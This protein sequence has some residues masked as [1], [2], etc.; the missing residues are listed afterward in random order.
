MYRSCVEPL[1]SRSPI[2]NAEVNPNVAAE[3]SPQTPTSYAV[4]AFSETAETL[5][6]T[7]LLPNKLAAAYPGQAVQVKVT[8]G[9]GA[10]HN[11]SLDGYIIRA[12]SAPQ[13]TIALNG[14]EDLADE[15]PTVGTAGYYVKKGV[16]QDVDA[17]GTE[18]AMV[19]ATVTLV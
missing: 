9:A 1:R 15:K 16:L 14:V 4:T 13:Y 11:E 2:E 7:V 5:V 8:G 10:L 3:T 6:A 12:G 18:I 17:T 19:F